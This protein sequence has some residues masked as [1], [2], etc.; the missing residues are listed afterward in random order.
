MWPM[1]QIPNVISKILLYQI[2]CISKLTGMSTHT[3]FVLF[4]LNHSTNNDFLN[5]LLLLILDRWFKRLSR[6]IGLL[7]ND[8]NILLLS[9]LIIYVVQI[10]ASDGYKAFLNYRL[11]LYT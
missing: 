11:G 5:W 4:S 3:H 8:L 1:L 7:K 10:M 9:I 6:M 2:N